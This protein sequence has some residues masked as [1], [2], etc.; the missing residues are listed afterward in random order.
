MGQPL[1]SE[2]ERFTHEYI[3]CESEPGEVNHLSTPRKRKKLDSLSSGERKGKSPNRM[4]V[5]A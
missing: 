1:L 2:L 3:V 5:Q 4:T